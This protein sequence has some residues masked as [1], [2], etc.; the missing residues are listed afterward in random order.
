MEGG[1]RES[2]IG[3]ASLQ[4]IAK[5]TFCRFLE[6]ACFGN[7]NPDNP[8]KRTEHAAVVSG[9]AQRKAA[10][11]NAVMNNARVMNRRPT[12]ERATVENETR[13]ISRRRTSG[14]YPPI[15]RPIRTHEEDDRP[16]PPKLPLPTSGTLIDTPLGTT[17]ISD[18]YDHTLDLL[19]VFMSHVQMYLFADCYSVTELQNSRHDV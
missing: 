11:R 7:Y 1:M 6:F 19:P 16:K 15:L 13:S 18:L 8:S 2:Q 14:R 17:S 10:I 12:S 5:A 3:A 9:E 4:D